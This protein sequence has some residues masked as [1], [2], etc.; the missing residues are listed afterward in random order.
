MNLEVNLLDNGIKELK[1]SG[2][3]DVKGA[4]EIETSFTAHFT[5]GTTAILIDMSEVEFLSSTGMRLL[6]FNAKTLANRKGKMV[7][8]NPQPLIWEALIVVGFD[9][10]IPIYDDLNDARAALKDPVAE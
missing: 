4:N 9:E 6:L 1:L 10:L 2:R 8:F 3:L 5:S 7:L